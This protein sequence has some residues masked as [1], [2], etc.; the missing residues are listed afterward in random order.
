MIAFI[1]GICKLRNVLCI[2]QLF[3]VMELLMLEN[4]VPL[5]RK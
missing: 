5:T 3:E 1:L 4:T 2:N